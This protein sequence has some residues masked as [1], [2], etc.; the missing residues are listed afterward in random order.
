MVSFL[1]RIKEIVLY[2]LEQL[3]W[4]GPRL[5]SHFGFWQGK[6]LPEICSSLTGVAESH[7]TVSDANELQCSEMAQRKYGAFL[8]TMGT[9]VGMIVGYQFVRCC[10]RMCRDPVAR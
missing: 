2:P 7:W 6:S 8:I 10:R 4:N 1:E 5:L 9:M 3:Y